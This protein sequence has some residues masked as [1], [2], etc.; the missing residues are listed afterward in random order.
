MYGIRNIPNELDNLYDEVK[1]YIKIQLIKGDWFINELKPNLQI[2]VYKH[3]FDHQKGY[4]IIEEN[5][6][7]LLIIRLEN[8][9]DV[10]ETATLDWLGEERLA[11]GPIALRREN[12]ASNKIIANLY[13]EVKASIKF[14]LELIEKVYSTQY[15]KHFYSE[16]EL[17]QFKQKWLANKT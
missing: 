5:N 14:D 13:K 3:P 16:E 11:R 1:E 12:E 17:Y 15:A 7:H 9:N 2:D 10:W 8:L 6:I 4:Q